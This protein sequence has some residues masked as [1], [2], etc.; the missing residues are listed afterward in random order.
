[1]GIDIGG[2][3]T[4]RS[5][6][7]AAL[8]LDGA[9]NWMSV[10]AGGVLTRPQTPYMRGQ[11]NGQTNPYSGNPMLVTADVNTGPWNNAT[12]YWTCP[13]AGY[14]LATMGGICGGMASSGYIY[15]YKNGSTI[16]FTHWNHSGSWHYC[17]LSVIASCAAGDTLSFGLQSPNPAN[18]G[19]YGQ[20]GHQMF[21]IALLA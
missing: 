14:Y 17:S 3:A 6:A 20:S 18:A 10:S 8:S 5:P 19:M 12:G 9:S 13:V 2:I 16:C 4:L 11:L 15:I 7:G 1:M 21:S